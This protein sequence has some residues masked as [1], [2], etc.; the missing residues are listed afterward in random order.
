M[1]EIEQGDAPNGEFTWPE[2]T[3]AVGTNVTANDGSTEFVRITDL[4]R[5]NPFVAGPNS[6]FV[7]HWNYVS[8]YDAVNP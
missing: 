5:Y 2:E 6:N 4:Q 7:G 3:K 1:V 8:S